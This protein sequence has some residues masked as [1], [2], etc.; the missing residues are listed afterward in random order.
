MC[1]LAWNAMGANYILFAGSLGDLS[2]S[3]WF[4]MNAI[5]PGALVFNLSAVLV[6]SLAWRNIVVEAMMF[7]AN[8]DVVV[9]R[10]R[11]ERVRKAVLA[12]CVFL[13]VFSFIMISLGKRF[14]GSF[15]MLVAYAACG[16]FMVTKSAKRFVTEIQSSSGQATAPNGRG[17]E[18]R[19]I[20]VC[21]HCDICPL[22]VS[23]I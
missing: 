3:R 18:I 21:M 7:K 11:E 22:L 9:M 5:A 13:F 14:E 12:L 15:V 17:G 6:I 10:K 2:T 4:Y 23:T 16:V 1:I 8:M 19:R 20:Q